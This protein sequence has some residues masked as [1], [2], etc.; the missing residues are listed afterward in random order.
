MFT[1]RIKQL[2]SLIDK[3]V[4]VIDIGCDHGLLDIYLTLYNQ[5]KCIASDIKQTAL[6]QAIDNIKKYDLEIQTV[7]SDGL[8]E[9]TI[10]KNTECV[11]AGM[12]TNTIID[13][14]ENEKAKQIDTFII[15]SNN[16]YYLL[17]KYMVKKGYQIIDEITFKDKNIRYIIIKFQK[18]INKYSKL[19]YILGPVLISKKDTDTIEYL[20]EELHKNNYIMS[21]LPKKYF[22]RKIKLNNLNKKIK[23]LI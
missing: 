3:N 22:I 1:K 9:I 18:G 14:L 17:R 13:I 21:N 2:A 8:N 10:E 4:N 15:Q 16:D 12:G 19:Q 7:L 11:I 20:K 5:N 23:K 6:N